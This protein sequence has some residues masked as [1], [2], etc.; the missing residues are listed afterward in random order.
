M[1]SRYIDVFK[2][3]SKKNVHF[4]W[5]LQQN[6]VDS[7]WLESKKNIKN[8]AHKPQNLDATLDRLFAKA[9]F[10]AV[11]HQIGRLNAAILFLLKRKQPRN[12]DRVKQQRNLSYVRFSSKKFTG[13]DMFKTTCVEEQERIKRILIKKTYKSK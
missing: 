6:Y 9:N 8:F 12:Y 4:T 5:Y 10:H 3:K 7:I 1:Q 11:R 2:Y 13:L